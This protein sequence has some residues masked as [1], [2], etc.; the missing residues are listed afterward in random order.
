M[1]RIT[2]G[3][4]LGAMAL[5][6]SSVAFVLGSAPF[7]P[8]IGLTY[9]SIPLAFVACLLGAWRLPVLAGHFGA[10]AWFTA[11]LSK[12]LSVYVDQMLLLSTVFGCSVG[13]ILYV[14]Y[15]RAK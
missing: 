11:P 5:I 7:T 9:V 15:V 14:S 13:V 3:V 4:S 8:A 12:S 2:V 1:R 6:L 10:M